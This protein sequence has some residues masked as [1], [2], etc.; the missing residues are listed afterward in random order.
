M[1]HGLDPNDFFALLDRAKK[2]EAQVEELAALLQ[3]AREEL[4]YI[5][6]DDRVTSE[7]IAQLDAALSRH[8]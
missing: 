5:N 1:S 3:E 6:R 4:D 8:R 2:A 7:L